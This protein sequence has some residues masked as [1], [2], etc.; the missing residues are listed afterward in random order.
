MGWT[1]R[2][3]YDSTAYDVWD[4]WLGYEK[5]NRGDNGP[6]PVDALKD[7]LAGYDPNKPIGRAPGWQTSLKSF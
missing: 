2:D 4:A 5:A 3:V 7:L 6:P 1:P